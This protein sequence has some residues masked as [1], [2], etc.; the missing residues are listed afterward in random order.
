LVTYAH[1]DLPFVPDWEPAVSFEEADAWWIHQAD[2]QS[3]LDI[4]L[5]QIFN[6]WSVLYKTFNH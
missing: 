6:G 1:C 2:H 3:E 4:S 5:Q